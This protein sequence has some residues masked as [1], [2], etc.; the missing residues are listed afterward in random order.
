MISSL[1]D[2][3]L[4]DFIIEILEEKEDITIVPALDK[5][6][7]SNGSGVNQI[8]CNWARDHNKRFENRSKE[9]KSII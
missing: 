5:G 3:F 7:H 8:V 1:K 9:R 4:F 2:R 6:T